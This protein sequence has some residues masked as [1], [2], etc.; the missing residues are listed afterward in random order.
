MSETFQSI[1]LA[2]DPGGDT[3]SELAKERKSKLLNMSIS[4][5]GYAVFLESFRDFLL[6][7]KIKHKFNCLSLSKIR[8]CPYVNPS[9]TVS[10]FR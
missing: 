4:L 5:T 1:D 7:D 3:T 9:V 2:S 6:F 8:V 10:Y